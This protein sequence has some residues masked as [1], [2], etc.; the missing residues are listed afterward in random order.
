MPQAAQGLGLH[1][2]PSCP[3]LGSRS[4]RGLGH[5]QL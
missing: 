4:G 5:S 3:R 1:S 2:G